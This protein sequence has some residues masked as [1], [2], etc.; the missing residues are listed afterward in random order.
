M[1]HVEKAPGGENSARDKIKEKRLL[2]YIRLI[3]EFGLQSSVCDVKKTETL[4]P[5]DISSL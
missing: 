4:K 1:Q 5:K 3:R 2:F